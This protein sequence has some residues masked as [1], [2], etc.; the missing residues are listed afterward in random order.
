M[1]SDQIMSLIRNILQFGGGILVSKGLI[2]EPD[3]LTAVG[4][5]AALGSVVWSMIAHKKK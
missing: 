5:L 3:M 1:N 4:A 2:T